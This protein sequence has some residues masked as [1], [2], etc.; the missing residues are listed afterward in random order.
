MTKENM[1]EDFI[2]IFG[3]ILIKKNYLKVFVFTILII[4]H[5]I[6]IPIIYSLWN[7]KN[8]CGIIVKKEWRARNIWTHLKNIW[9]KR[10]SKLLN[11]TRVKKVENGIKDIIK[12]LGFN[13]IEEINI[14]ISVLTA[15]L[16]IPILKLAANIVQINAVG[17]QEHQLLYAKYVGKKEKL[18]D[19][20]LLGKR[21]S[22][23][24]G[25]LVLQNLDG[26]EEIIVYNIQV[27]NAG[28]YYANNILVSNCEVSVWQLNHP[29]NLDYEYFTELKIP[30]KRGKYYPNEYRNEPEQFDWIS[31]N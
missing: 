1:L 31:R 17:K 10:G 25:N 20:C 14:N 13:F 26:E 22:E 27:E 3:N 7:L 15:I 2:S 19:I 24:V 21:Q 6:I 18:K 16:N 29:G 23:P 30:R 9:I 4:T 28:C 12:M 8:I 5:L 11:G